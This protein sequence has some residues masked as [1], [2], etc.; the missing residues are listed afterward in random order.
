[1]P[2]MVSADIPIEWDELPLGYLAKSH[3]GH[4][5][6]IDLNR[7]NGIAYIK[8]PA[9]VPTLRVVRDVFC[10]LSDSLFLDDLLDAVE[11]MPKR[12]YAHISEHSPY[13]IKGDSE[14]VYFYN[15]ATGEVVR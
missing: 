13:C 6:E 3:D 15:S 10:A 14:G 8:F 2:K 1:M 4:L 7:Y 5:F 9:H 12:Q 11:E